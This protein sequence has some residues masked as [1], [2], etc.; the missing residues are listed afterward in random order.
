MYK[1]NEYLNYSKLIIRSALE[2]ARI[3]L[4][5]QEPVGFSNHDAETLSVFF[6]FSV[7]RSGTQFFSR[8]L[9]N[10]PKAL[11]L[12]EPLRRDVLEY[13]RSFNDKYNYDAYI[14]GFRMKY[15][16]HNVSHQKI[17]IYGEV[18]SVLRRHA[19]ALMFNIPNVKGLYLIRDGRDVVRS[20]M[21][22]G[23]MS[24]SWFYNKITP[25]NDDPYFSKWHDW[26]RFEK[27]CWVWA[28]ENS[29]LYR[30]FGPA[31]KFELLL[32]DYEYFKS[33]LLD[34]LQLDINKNIWEKERLIK[35]KNRTVRFTIKPYKNWPVVWQDSF[36]EICGEMMEKHG[37]S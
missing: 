35:S 17:N 20:M 34:E 31:M 7:G 19:A 30:Q 16:Q 25:Q 36:W 9:N 10:D 23:A 3:K 1:I 33:N 12:H 2:T 29:M 11:V 15:I 21:S 13:A 5:R 28:S 4:R 26:G 14:K 22:R 32:K 18:N 24:N 8:L 6:I 37:Y 27:C